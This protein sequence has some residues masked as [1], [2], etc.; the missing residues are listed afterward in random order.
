MSEEKQ[1]EL[2]TES[3][4]N[5]KDKEKPAFILRKGKKK[6]PV[7]LHFKDDGEDNITAK[8]KKMLEKTV[9]NGDL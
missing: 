3:D 9:R 8:I 6:Y 2:L 5:G 7:F 4:R 1:K